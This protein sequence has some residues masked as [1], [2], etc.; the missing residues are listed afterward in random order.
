MIKKFV[1]K[2][3]KSDGQDDIR[4]PTDENASFRLMYKDLFIGTLAVNAGIWSF[5]Y[6]QEFK[7]Q[8]EIQPLVDFP[9]TNQVYQ[10]N[11]L[12]PFFSYRIPGLNQ[13]AVQEIL[14]KDAIDKNNEVALLKKFGKNTIFN[15]YMLNSIA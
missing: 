5:T 1:N 12:W 2:L 15:P 6:S 13:P 3:W 11:Q 14:K 4:T 9:D 8:E 10:T 7:M